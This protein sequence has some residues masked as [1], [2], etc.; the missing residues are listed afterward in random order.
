MPILG[1]DTSS[2]QAVLVLA[3]KETILVERYL[4]VERTHMEKLLPGLDLMLRSRGFLPQRVEA[5]AVGLGPGSFTGTRLG[6]VVA[7]TLAQ[8][9]GGIPIVGIPSLDILANSV[10]GKDKLICAVVDAR[11]N[12]VYTAT[13]R[14]KETLERLDDYR[15]ASPQ[16]L[17]GYLGG[18]GEDIIF[19]G[20]G[21]RNYAR[22]FKEQLGGRFYRA[23]TKL[24]YPQASSLMSLAAARFL[25]GKTDNLFQLV[26]I[27]VRRPDIRPK[28][29]R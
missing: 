2:P 1:L 16:D 9:L 27:Y 10:V 6:V 28:T 23:A 26:P 14:R 3:D 8:A 22:V 7:K 20:D 29:R 15:A 17:A 18:L 5:I 19:V 13:Y 21:L 12:E 24:W 11:R 25:Q 4:A